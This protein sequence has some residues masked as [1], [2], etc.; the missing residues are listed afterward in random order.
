MNTQQLIAAIATVG[1][2]AFASTAAWADDIT[3]V[4]DNF[5]PSKTRAELQAEVQQA[6]AAGVTHFVT[7]VSD[8]KE[9][10]TATPGTLSREQVRANLPNEPR[11][12][13]ITYNPAA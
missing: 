10:D 5:K 11:T 12:R 7:E 9:T 2:F 13:D 1:A 6:R 4:R 8:S 3:V